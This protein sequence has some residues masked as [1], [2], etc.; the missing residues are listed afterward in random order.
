MKRLMQLSAIAFSLAIAQ[1]PAVAQTTNECS[2]YSI[3]ICAGARWTDF[4][5]SG[6]GQCRLTEYA[7]CMNG[8]PPQEEASYKAEPS[9]AVK[10]IRS[11]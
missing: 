7:R 9:V 6:Y 5:Y 4:G 1:S 10:T 11:A 8:E 3:T 2:L